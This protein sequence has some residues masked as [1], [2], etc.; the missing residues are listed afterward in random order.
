VQIE[1]AVG[2]EHDAGVAPG[3]LLVVNRRDLRSNLSVRLFPPE[4]HPVVLPGVELDGQR[5]YLAVTPH[6]VVEVRYRE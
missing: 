2:L 4:L 3:L 5:Q 1:D 6:G